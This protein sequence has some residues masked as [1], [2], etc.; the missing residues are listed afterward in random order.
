MAISIAGQYT[1]R[2]YRW[3]QFKAIAASK[4]FLHQHAD[5][6]EIY[7]IWGYDGPEVHICNI[8]KNAVPYAVID[9]GYSQA[10]NDSDKSDFETNY[11]ALSN[12]ALGPRD[13]DGASIVRIKAAKAGWTYVAVSAEI[14]TST[15]GGSLYS[16]Y[17]DGTNRGEFTV[18]CY[19]ADDVEVTTPGLLNANLA[20]IV[21]TVVDF[22]PPYDYEVIGGYLRTLT[23]IDQDMRLWIIAVPDIPA[24]YGGSKEM[25]CGI[26]LRYLSPGNVYE[27][28]GRVSKF[29]KYDATYHTNKVRLIFKHVA[30]MTENL[31]IVLEI[32]KS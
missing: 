23:S 4:A 7:T 25:C 5:D 32:Y 3:T 31:S 20:T 9:S 21:K 14:V 17:V 28:D 6:G 19:N 13:T 15:I 8:W 18:K 2:E 22:E 1:Q 16:K 26:N 29:L 10:Q 11:L 12:K 24:N 27:V 30:G